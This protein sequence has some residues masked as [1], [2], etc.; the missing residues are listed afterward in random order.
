[1]GGRFAVTLCKKV[2]YCLLLWSQG[3]GSVVLSMTVFVMI[4]VEGLFTGVIEQSGS[5]FAHWAVSR[6][7]SSPSL[8]FRMFVTAMGCSGNHT[9]SRLKRCLQQLPS[10]V[11]QEVILNEPEV[12]GV[13]TRCECAITRGERGDNPM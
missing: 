5:P 4:C 7:E 11:V 12:R 3:N 9:A 8:Y 10:H 1:M 6:H 2:V 13:I